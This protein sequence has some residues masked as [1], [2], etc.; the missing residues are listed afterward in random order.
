MK[1]RGRPPEYNGNS[2][3]VKEKSNRYDQ[4]IIKNFS[5]IKIGKIKFKVIT[6]LEKYLRDSYQE[7][8]IFISYKTTQQGY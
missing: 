3:A 2:R 4:I 6:V 1:R 8:V 5:L 7:K